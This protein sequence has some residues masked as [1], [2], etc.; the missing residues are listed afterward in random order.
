MTKP[1]PQE[2][3]RQYR[4]CGDWKQ[5]ERTTPRPG[6]WVQTRNGWERVQ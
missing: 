2:R 5:I 4:Q 3:Q 6:E 1:R